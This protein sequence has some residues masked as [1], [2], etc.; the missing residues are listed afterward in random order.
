M[1]LRKTGKRI[2]GATVISIA[3]LTFG[4]TT[5]SAAKKTRITIES[6]RSEDLLIWQNKIIPAFE[7]KHPNIKV[8]F[9]PTNPTEYN[10]ALN[11]KL[12]AGTAGDL[13]TCRPFSFEEMYK[14]KQLTSLNN[15]KGI[16]SFSEFARSAWT[17]DGT[18]YCMP[19]ASVIHGFIYN[20]RIFKKLKL[21]VPKTE[22]EFFDLLK[23][24]KEKSR[25]TPLALGT[26][27]QWEAHHVGY[28]NIGPNYWKGEAGRLSVIEGVQKL[29]DTPYLK[30]F[31]TLAK[32]K[33]YLSR[34]YQAQSYSDSQSLFTLGRA[35]IYPGGSWEISGFNKQARFKMGAFYP[36]PKKGAKCYISDQL[37]IGM[38]VNGASKKKAA[39]RKFLTW[40]STK[41]FAQI[42]NQ[43]LPG[44][45][46]LSKHKVTSA[47]PLVKDYLSFRDHCD[48]TLRSDSTLSHGNPPLD[49]ETWAASA[50]V[51]NGKLTPEAAVKR[52]QKSLSSW[53]KPQKN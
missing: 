20:K 53:Y 14:R 9:K 29:T 11:A 15:L 39:A 43:S 30:T 13:I 49:R 32:W 6:W 26:A 3:A 21:Q 19:M 51:L 46:A 36:P 23:K 33:P 17:S 34:G 31:Q 42:F 5:A 18:T 48:S 7:K 4:I 10:S 45:F 2:I 16:G 44:F 40:M 52:L 41:E 22:Q 35:A 25:Y 38:G 24:I 27:D 28:Q 50:E 12:L 47:D 1:N 37:D 8:Q